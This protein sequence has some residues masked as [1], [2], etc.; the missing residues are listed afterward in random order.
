MQTILLTLK[1][2]GR[3]TAL[4][5]VVLDLHLLH[6]LGNWTGIGMGLVC[7]AC[8]V[9]SNCMH[10]S[11]SVHSLPTCRDLKPMIAPLWTVRVILA[12]NPSCLLG[13]NMRERGVM[14]QQISKQ[15][16]WLLN[17]GHDCFVLIV[18]LPLSFFSHP[19]S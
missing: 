18:F 1:A 9:P 19:P 3:D 15:F 4:S 14:C 16:D 6:Q 7:G 12:Q 10:T 8:V 2:C 13:K 17:C 11:S 5:S